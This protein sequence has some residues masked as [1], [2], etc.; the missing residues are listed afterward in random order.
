L[1]W[2]NGLSH[3]CSTRATRALQRSRRGHTRRRS[4]SPRRAAQWS[5][6]SCNS[7]QWPDNLIVTTQRASLPYSIPPV[8]FR[9]FSGGYSRA[10]ANILECSRRLISV[11]RVSHSPRRGTRCERAPAFKAR[12]ARPGVGYHSK[13]HGTWRWMRRRWIWLVEDILDLLNDALGG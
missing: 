9:I 2:R 6:R 5:T 11:R 12:V 10:R 13:P 7:F 3:S 1:L 4:A 8:R